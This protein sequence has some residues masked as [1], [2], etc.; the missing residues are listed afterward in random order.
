M[1]LTEYFKPLI[2]TY[3]TKTEIIYSTRNAAFQTYVRV[4]NTYLEIIVYTKIIMS[5]TILF[6]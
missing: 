3:H 5:F 2:S 1:E 4:C 6:V